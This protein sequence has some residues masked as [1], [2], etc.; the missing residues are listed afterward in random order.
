MFKPIE[1]HHGEGM[2][3]LSV[4]LDTV[5]GKNNGE[6]SE[7]QEYRNLYSQALSAMRALDESSANISK[8]ESLFTSLSNAQQAE[9]D[10]LKEIGNYLAKVKTAHQNPLES[11][12]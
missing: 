10:A 8:L 11:Y 4:T 3:I 7:S 2:K 9:R 5:R 6:A 1:P 12:F